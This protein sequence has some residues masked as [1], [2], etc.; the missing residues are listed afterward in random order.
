MVEI[1]YKNRAIFDRVMADGPIVDYD[2]LHTLSLT[3]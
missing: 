3:L 1:D 2:E